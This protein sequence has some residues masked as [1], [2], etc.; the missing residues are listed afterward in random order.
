MSGDAIRDKI[1]GRARL[2]PRAVKLPTY[3]LEA[4]QENLEFLPKVQA[5]VTGFF[6]GGAIVRAESGPLLCGIA[7]TFRAPEGSSALAV[8]DLV[9]VAL[10]LQQHQSTAAAGDKD[11]ADGMIL[12]R[13]PRSTVLVR[14]QPRSAKRFDKHQ[15]P[16]ID[17]VLVANMDQLLIVTSVRQP[18]LRP[19]VMD[20][21]LIVAE[22]GELAPLLVINK[23]DLG[24][25]EESAVMGFVELGLKV[26]LCSATTGKGLEELRAAL[27]G[28]RSVLAGASGV[29]KSTL[30]N[31][32]IPDA[33]VATRPVR[34][35]DE[36]GRHTTAAACIYDLPP[37]ADGLIV[38]TP[39]VRELGIDLTAAQLPWY[40]PEFDEH[41]ANCRF[42]NCTHTHEP[43]C[44]VLAAVEAGKI[45]PRRYES[46]LRILETLAER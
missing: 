35:R 3:R 29:G 7:K 44:A 37:P 21:F 45:Q 5:L 9:T 39:G 30:V 22:R 38:D 19:A 16:R 25:P 18:P 26:V 33:A 28:R 12:A 46:Y 41:A 4:P 23:I 2:T 43:D 32:L 36:R 17:K 10:T 6:P 15:T 42:N 24:R 20:R 8:G 31:A 14:P 27:A 1:A 13:Q 34:M 11:R 40:F